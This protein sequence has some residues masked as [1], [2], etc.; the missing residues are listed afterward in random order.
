LDQ[1]KVADDSWAYL[2]V[3]GKT[4]VVRDLNSLQVYQWN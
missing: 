1:T 4:I 2:A 3:D